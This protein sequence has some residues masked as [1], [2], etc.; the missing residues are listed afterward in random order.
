MMKIHRLALRTA[1]LSLGV[2]GL[3]VPGAISAAQAATGCVVTNQ[4]LAAATGYTEFIAGSGSRGSES[5]GA[6]AW[7]GNLNANGMTVGTRL[8]SAPSDPTLV[9]AGTH[10]TF[11]LQKGS[12][13]VVPKTGVNF[14]G[15]GTYLNTNPIDFAGAFATLTSRSAS[16]GAAA[17][18]GTAALGTVAGQ[19]YL[20]LSG[21]DPQLNIFSLS[22]AQLSSGAGI[23]YDVPAGST[24]LVNVAATTVALQG[25]MWIKQNGSYTQVQDNVMM[26]SW[27]GILW[28]FPNA[29]SITMNVGSA[30]GGSILAP[31]ANLQVT[32][33][34][35]TIGQIIADRFSSN[36]ETHQNNFPSSACLPPLSATPSPT[37]PAIQLTKTASAVNDVDGNGHDAG[38]T[39]T[40]SFAVKNTGDV[41][42]DQLTLSDPLLGAI[43]CPSAPLAVGATASCSSKTYT[44]TPADIATG[45]R[46]NTA[47]VTGRA[48]DG[49]VVRDDDTV[50]TALVSTKA[51][52]VVSKAVDKSSPRVGETV[53]YTLGAT[54]NG[55]ATATNVVLTDALPAGVTFVSASAPCTYSAGTVT[56]ELGNLA[57]G[58]SRSVQIQAK[59]DPLPAGAGAV[60]HDI[61]VQKTEVHVDVE[62]NQSSTVSAV[63]ETGYIA[64]DGSGRIDHVDQGTGTYADVAIT[65]SY[66]SALDTWTVTLSNDASGRAQGKAFAVCLKA[67]TNAADGHTH[68]LVV[69]A[70]IT[71]AP[72]VCS[73]DQ[74][75]IAVGYR[76]GATSSIRCLDTKV[77]EAAGHQH[78]LGLALLRQSVLVPARETVEYQLTCSDNAKGI[79]AGQQFAPGLVDLGNDP[80]PKTRAFRV[81]NPTS[82]ALVADFSLLCLEVRTAGAASSGVVTNSVAGSTS[83]VETAYGDNTASATF[84]VNVAPP[85]AFAASA[86]SVRRSTVATLVQCSAG[87][88]A[89]TG[90]LTLVAARTQ[91]IGGTTVR[92]GAVLARS[93]FKIAPGKRATVHLKATKLGKKALRSKALKKAKIKIGNRSKTVTVRR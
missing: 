51:N 31:K 26:S 87:V 5:E 6:I 60:Q 83:T 38:D 84:T 85:V 25:Q 89:C 30:W 78:D 54:N 73:A 52:L 70:P 11:N 79:V 15:G 16:W 91:K 3:A 71:Q 36:F 10:G 1:A 12:A 34:G 68:P 42:L 72:F 39:I 55:P 65:E 7:G 2:A 45:S 33:V 48:P 75:A 23:A 50:T 19:T 63:C 62:P 40:Y 24:V 61:D 47:T 57:P 81:F 92:A 49:T 41:A 59:V 20:V 46:T 56:C 22:Q 35:H 37:N 80:R 4:P 82:G 58:S 18:N 43:T 27:P 69:S 14:N 77:G 32:N 44:I 86:V 28:N 8:N 29:T 9:V 90:T 74:V 64:V 21:N 76:S 13:Y 67:R 66:A 17:A 88:R 53:T 93:T